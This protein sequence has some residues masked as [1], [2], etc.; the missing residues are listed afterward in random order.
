MR[1]C[2]NCQ[3]MYFDAGSPSYSEWTPGSAMSMECHKDHWSL[4]YYDNQDK[5]RESLEKAATCPD[6]QHSDRAKALGIPDEDVVPF[7]PSPGKL[8]QV[9]TVCNKCGTQL[10]MYR[11]RWSY[12]RFA[13]CPTC[14]PAVSS[15]VD[16]KGLEVEGQ[17]L[18]HQVLV[19]EA[20][21]D[22]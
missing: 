13:M 15:V 1:L 11:D 3:F 20:N 17:P 7:T 18:T 16:S 4:D 14:S 8:V 9:P 2:Y 22:A 5:L 21:Y 19:K 10:V 12:Q 6:Y